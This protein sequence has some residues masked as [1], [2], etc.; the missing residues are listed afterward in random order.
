VRGLARC[1]LAAVLLTSVGSAGS[2]GAADDASCEE[3][4][5]SAQARM[6]ADGRH[7][8]VWRNVWMTTAVTVFVGD[9]TAAALVKTDLR[10][11]FAFGA[12]KALFIPVTLLLRPPR[13]IADA[14]TLDERVLATSLDGHVADACL[15]LSRARDLRRSSDEDSALR[16]SWLAHAV[17]IVGSLA[18][19]GVLGSVNGHWDRVALETGATIGVGELQI[20]TF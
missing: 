10:V 13:V 11:D 12:A 2:A 1:A 4:L 9:V 7:V 20:L 18:M 16:T 14:R 3:Q 8:T 17:V 19:G 6:D 15:A 5:R